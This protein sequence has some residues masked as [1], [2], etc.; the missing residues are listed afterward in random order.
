MSLEYELLS[1]RVSSSATCHL[2]TGFN[3]ILIACI[4]SFF[5][6][7]IF[8]HDPSLELLDTDER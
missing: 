6:K 2:I 3:I 7:K 8:M 5:F 1:V 4:L